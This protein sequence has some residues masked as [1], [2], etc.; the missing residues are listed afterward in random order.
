MALVNKDM[1]VI[2]VIP[3]YTLLENFKSKTAGR[4]NSWGVLINFTSARVKYNCEDRVVTLK[5]SKIAV[6]ALPLI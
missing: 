5:I 4:K 6:L 2:K 3:S 1:P